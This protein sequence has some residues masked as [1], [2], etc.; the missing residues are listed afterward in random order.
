MKIPPLIPILTPLFLLSLSLITAAAQNNKEP[1]S[2]A[3]YFHNLPSKVY[4]FDDTTNILWYDGFE[5]NVHVSDDGGKV[6]KPAAGIE[7]GK[8]I[9][10][11]EHPFDNNVVSNSSEMYPRNL[12]SDELL[13]RLSFWEL[14]RRIGEQGTEGRHGNHSPHQ[15]NP[16]STRIPSSHSIQTLSIRSMRSSRSA[17]ILFFLLFPC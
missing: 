12:E 11:I 15:S 13:S 16:T 14:T 17:P 9:A 8:A 3:T 6:F 2:T 5:R 4:C 7:K 1:I 10:L